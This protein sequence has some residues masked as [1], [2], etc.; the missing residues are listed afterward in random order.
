M[1]SYKER[2]RKRVSYIMQFNGN[3]PYSVED[4]LPKTLFLNVNKKT[5]HAADYNNLPVTAFSIKVYLN[6]CLLYV[7]TEPQKP[8]YVSSTLLVDPGFKWSCSSTTR[9]EKCFCTQQRTTSRGISNDLHKRN[10]FLPYDGDLFSSPSPPF[11]CSMDAT[12]IARR[13]KQ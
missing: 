12:F 11:P 8:V 7:C 10:Q 9:A 1:N 4:S 3:I 2:K 13:I 5:F 6:Y